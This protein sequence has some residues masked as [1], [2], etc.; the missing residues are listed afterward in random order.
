MDIIPAPQISS[1]KSSIR[2]D[3]T[4]GLLTVWGWGDSIEPTFVCV[5]NY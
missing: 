2:G 5:E 3:V 4:A 1:C